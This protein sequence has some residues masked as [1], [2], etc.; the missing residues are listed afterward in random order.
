MQDERGFLEQFTR[1]LAAA[2]QASVANL[3]PRA[4][5]ARAQGMRI[6]TAVRQADD[7]TKVLM[8]P[9]WGVP[10]RCLATAKRLEETSLLLG[11]ALQQNKPA[12][13]PAAVASE[14]AAPTAAASASPEPPK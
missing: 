13:A 6:W 3:R 10:S 5:E 14:P 12:E 7:K 4:A 11:Q 9:Y 1:A 8:V 2:D